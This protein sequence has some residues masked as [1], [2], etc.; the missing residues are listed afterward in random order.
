[1][2]NK[3]EE[4]T[5]PVNARRDF[6]KNS[7][8]G[9]GGY[10]ATAAIAGCGG[11]SQPAAVVTPTSS[12]QIPSASA[13]KFGIMA[14]SQWY[15]PDDG[16]NPFSVAQDI[17]DQ[18]MQQMINNGVKFVAHMGDLTSNGAGTPVDIYGHALFVQ[19]LYNAGIGYFTMRGNHE[20]SAT[21]ATYFQT[22][23]PQTQTGVHNSAPTAVATLANPDSSTLPVPANNGTKFTLGSNFSSPDPWGSGD[24]KG[25]SYSFDYQNIRFVVLDQF[26]V[27]DAATN[28]NYSLTTSIASQ[29]SWITAQLSGRPSGSHAIVLTH[30]GLVLPY[31]TDVLLGSD[32]GQN[33]ATT[34][35]FMASLSQNGV[36]YLFCGHD[37]MHDRSIV[38][39][40]DGKS[41]PIN[42]VV[43]SSNSCYNYFPRNPSVVS[44]DVLND[45][46]SVAAFGH[47]RRSIVAQELNTFGY[48]IATVDGAN[49][50]FEYYSSP[51]YATFDISQHQWDLTTT[52]PLNFTLRETFGYSLNGQQFVIPYGGSFTAVTSKSPNATV[53]QILSGTN[54]GQGQDYSGLQFVRSINTGWATGVGP[55]VSDV[56][57]LWGIHSSLVSE[58]SETYTLQLSYPSTVSASALAAGKVAIATLSDGGTFVNAANATFGGT[59]RF[60]SGPWNDSYTLG[61]Y[62]V[63][64]T[65]NVA[66]AV[67]N[68]GGIFAVTNFS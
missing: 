41:S 40:S 66:W 9:M 2:P 15:Q 33:Q 48:Y 45:S 38:T 55:Q 25:L 11:S 64:T 26:T 10:A 32:P 62:G 4:K 3:K 58:Q 51:S 1:M 24:L 34:D 14:D 21:A 60:V 54:I 49:I 52:P 18:V 29:Q 61:T 5:I 68:Y 13:W 31:H 56:L 8:F 37:H 28:S 44:G 47:A 12:T 43:S 39:A 36:Q 50:S 20:D 57:Y 67:V 22:A 19:A 16:K 23:F 42:Q 35:A 30:K 53:A 65:K 27:A 17:R 46:Y 63:D 6:I 59:S 7:V